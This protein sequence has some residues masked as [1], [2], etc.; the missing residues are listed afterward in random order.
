VAREAVDAA[1]TK[2]A[3]ERKKRVLLKPSLN[4]K[5]LHKIKKIYF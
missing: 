3:E 2:A 5:K 1:K 4:I